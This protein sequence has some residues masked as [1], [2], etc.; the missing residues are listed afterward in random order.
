MAIHRQQG[1]QPSDRVRVTIP[2]H[3]AP[4]PGSPAGEPEELTEPPGQPEPVG[5][6]TT[7]PAAEPAPMRG[8]RVRVIW[9]MIAASLLPGG[10]AA[11]APAFWHGLPSW[12]H[13]TAYGVSGTLLLAVIGLIVKD[14]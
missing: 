5:Q 6:P 2:E 4:N 12:A 7:S 10:I 11:L 9:G 8:G 3:G 14:G 1:V 13:W